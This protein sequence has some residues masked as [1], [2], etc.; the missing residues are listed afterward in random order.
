MHD[1]AP[2]ASLAP[3]ELF[4]GNESIRTRLPNDNCDASL[5]GIPASVE[6]KSWKYHDGK[7]SNLEYLK[8]LSKQLR[9]RPKTVGELL[10]PFMISL[11]HIVQQAIDSLGLVL[12]SGNEEMMGTVIEIVVR[13]LTHLLNLYND[14]DTWNKTGRKGN[15]RKR[16]N[17]M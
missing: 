14:R 12:L 10:D 11:Q 1:T 15:K 6:L 5:S 7:G 3:T 4:D 2:V 8:M 16:I 13:S 9:L 17:G